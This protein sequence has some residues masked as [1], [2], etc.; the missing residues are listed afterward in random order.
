MIGLRDKVIV[1]L[2]ID[3]EVIKGELGIMEQ[4]ALDHPLEKLIAMWSDQIT[5]TKLMVLLR[6]LE[7]HGNRTTPTKNRGRQAGDI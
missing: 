6:R 1:R 3:F 7:N 2:E 4:N 5:Q